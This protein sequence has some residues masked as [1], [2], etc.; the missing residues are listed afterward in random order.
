[1]IVIIVPVMVIM[2]IST[3]VRSLL[4][5]FV[6]PAMATMVAA[7]APRF[8]GV[9]GNC[10]RGHSGKSCQRAENYRRVD[11]RHGRHGTSHKQSHHLLDVGGHCFLLTERAFQDLRCRSA[12]LL[13]VAQR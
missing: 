4:M 5:G 3:V 10:R 6:M 1:M 7:T 11:R 12:R 9:G 2:M 13:S 8:R